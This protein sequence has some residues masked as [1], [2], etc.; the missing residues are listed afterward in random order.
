M[1]GLHSH[2]V[3]V[4]RALDDPELQTKFVVAMYMLRPVTLERGIEA[5]VKRYNEISLC[6]SFDPEV[7]TCNYS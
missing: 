6:D 1:L 7:M 4:I 3:N 5:F 2:G